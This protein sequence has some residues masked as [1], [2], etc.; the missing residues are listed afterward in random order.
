MSK[1]PELCGPERSDIHSS[2]S[3][4]I[5]NH[6]LGITIDILKFGVT[7]FPLLVTICTLPTRA[8]EPL[9]FPTHLVQ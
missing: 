5:L 4:R 2:T 9:P 3:V 1:G 8:S 6:G 7:I